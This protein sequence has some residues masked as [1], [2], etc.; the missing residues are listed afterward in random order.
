MVIYQKENIFSKKP[1][2][3]K[4]QLV[5]LKDIN[6]IYRIPMVNIKTILFSILNSGSSCWVCHLI[7]KLEYSN[8]SRN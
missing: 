8:N 3:R 6:T 7:K 2:K 5:L 4:Y 1:V